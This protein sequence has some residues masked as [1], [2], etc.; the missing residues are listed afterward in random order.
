MFSYVLSTAIELGSWCGFHRGCCV[1][2]QQR[3]V[4]TQVINSNERQ[5][6]CCHAEALSLHRGTLGALGKLPASRHLS[7]D[8]LLLMSCPL[9]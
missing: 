9:T 5:F 8:G 2:F 1:P 6:P 7:S 3:H 4:V